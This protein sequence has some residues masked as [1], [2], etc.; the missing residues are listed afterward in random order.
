M[1]SFTGSPGTPFERSRWR[2]RRFACYAQHVMPQGGAFNCDLRSALI[3]VSPAKSLDCKRKKI[4]FPKPLGWG[5]PSARI[6]RNRQRPPSNGLIE[7]A[8]ITLLPYT[9][10]C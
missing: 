7:R 9:A 5:L 10:Q 4:E 8:R 3:F 2:G 6:R 1:N